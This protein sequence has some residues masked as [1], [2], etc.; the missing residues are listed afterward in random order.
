MKF[1]SK[2]KLIINLMVLEKSISILFH[3]P[4]TFNALEYYHKMPI[5]QKKRINLETN[6]VDSLREARLRDEAPHL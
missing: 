4:E 3:L 5:E 6:S 1:L 2:I